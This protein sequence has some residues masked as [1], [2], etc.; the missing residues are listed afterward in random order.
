[1]DGVLDGLHRFSPDDDDDAIEGEE[2]PS[3][4]WGNFMVKH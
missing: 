4:N 1:M 2:V 3:K